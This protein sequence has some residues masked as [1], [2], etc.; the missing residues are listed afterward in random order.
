MW[1]FFSTRFAFWV[2][3]G[4]PVSFWPARLF[5][6]HMGISINMI[7][8]VALL[9]ALGI[10]MDD[11]IVISESIG[12]QLRK[13]RGALRA[14]IDGT[15]KVAAGVVSLL[16]DHLVYLSGLVDDYR[17]IGANSGRYPDCSDFGDY[18][19][20]HRGVS[21]TAASPLPTHCKFP[22]HRRRPD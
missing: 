5:C 2:V 9:L 11:A 7:S 22:Q 19:L 17:N 20:T 21:D 4:L 12:T 1:M 6:Q 3:M 15:Q 8:M 13:G 16:S 14:V 10:L 18:R